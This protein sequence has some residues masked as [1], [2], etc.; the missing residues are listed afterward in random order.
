MKRF[1]LLIFT[2]T[3]G[4][5]WAQPAERHSFSFPQANLGKALDEIQLQF[6]VKYS[7][8]DSIVA[9]KTITLPRQDYSLDEL[10]S[11]IER[12]TS[13]T[14]TKING[15]YYSVSQNPELV[16]AVE[17]LDE[18]LVEQ[19]LSRGI[20]KDSQKATISPKQVE[21][22]PGVTDAD[23]M[24]SL[25]QLPG[26]K[27]PN[28]TATGLHIRGGTPDQNLILWDGIRMYHPGHLFGM[29]SGFNPNVAQTVYYYNK[30]TDPKFGERVSGVI[31][32]RTTDKIPDSLK[33]E[34][35]INALDADVY[36]RMPLIKKKIGLQLSARKSFTEFWP[37]PTF[38][39]YAEK[40][41]QNTDFKD[42]DDS[43]RFAFQDYSAKLNVDV[44]EKTR[45][46]MTGIYIGNHLDF[47]TAD[48]V[49]QHKNQKMDIR[50]SGFSANWFQRYGTKLTQK[51]LLYYSEYRFGYDRKLDDAPDGY[52][53]FEKLNRITN[54]GAEANF[55]YRADDRLSIE[56]GYQLFGS[57][58]SHAFTS[59][60]PGLEIEL[61]Q[62]HLFNIT[63]AGYSYLSYEFARWSFRGGARYNYFS[64]IKA[65]SFEPRASVQK[66]LDEH[67]VLQAGYE[68]RSQIESQIRETAANDLSLENYVW[69][70]SDGK[71]YPVEKANQYNMGFIWK[72]KSL[73]FDLDAYYKT[74]DGVTSL[75][76][77][78]LNLSD[79]V[80]HKGE[81]YT[82]G[83]DV[84]LQ[85][86]A[87]TW[88]AWITYTYQDSQNRYDGLNGGN[89]FPINSDT[90]H[91]FSI[92]F[93]KKWRRFSLAAGWFW[94]SGKPF[95]TIDDSGDI[96]SFN[97]MRL[98]D[99]HRLDI[100]AAYEFNGKNWKGK[101]GF[102]V[103]NLYDS[104]T[105][106]SREYERHYNDLGDIVATGYAVR[107]Y[108]SL[109]ITPNVFFRVR[110]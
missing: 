81:G 37:S 85:K 74:I 109:G 103:Y 105:L 43:N 22:L 3:C 1:A 66:N 42:F 11:E 99:Y 16:F 94:H 23:I 8:A 84:L 10:N 46:S 50:N 92:S 104:R 93:H 89:Y 102:S 51:T 24:L 14:V 80:P 47:N 36:F 86:N 62:N 96:L 68:R 52:H 108:Y 95:S 101:I 26:V 40:V 87:P 64:N 67:F 44:N 21:E 76:F 5:S 27:S 4:F 55:D 39:S 70:L 41:F 53:L 15:R 38:D 58:V 83:L 69:T 60:T 25:Q 20:S 32:I 61:D 35:G 110:F 100:S 34:A 30:A 91:A 71:E 54:S 13:L 79:P 65:E 82:K 33:A 106:I 59:K 6:D 75:S 72:N 19:F 31:D 18:I 49:S 78:F 7:Y 17:Q 107:D 63:Q 73:L 9:P 77:G 56:F 90:K 28:E 48:S 88:R 98:P 57:D 29:I 97:S 12:Q 2:L 45:F